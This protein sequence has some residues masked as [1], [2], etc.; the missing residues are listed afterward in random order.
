MAVL[1]TPPYLQFFDDDGLPLSGG[2]VYTY[3]ATGTFSVGKATYTTVAGDVEHPNPV[4]LD[5]SGRP[6]TGNGSIWLSGTYDFKVTDSLDNT[7]ETTLGVTAFTTLPPESDAYF[8]TFSG[9]G[10]QTAFTCSE[11]LGTDEKAI[12]VWV[13]AGAG[14]GYEIQNPSAYTINAT[15]LTFNVAPASGTNNIY[16]SAPSL[17]VGAASSSAADA[18][19]SAADAAAS[20]AA[21]LASETAAANYATKLSGTS[22]TSVAIATG[23]KAFTTQASKF[24]TVGNFLLIASDADEANYMHGQVT[25]YSGTSLTV[26]VIDTGGSGTFTDWV[27]TLSGT[28]GAVGATGSINDLSGVPSGTVTTAD[29]LV[30]DDVSDAHITRSCT[31]ADVILLAQMAN[32][33]V[34]SIYQNKTSSTN[35]ATLLGFG[36]WVQLTDVFLVARGGTYTSTGGAATDS[37]TISE[38]N[39][40]SSV[41]IDQASIGDVNNATTG[42]AKIAVSQNGARSC[43]FDISLGAGTAIT[44]DTIPPYQAIYTWE[45]TA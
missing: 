15:A 2:K 8:Q 23:S 14:K 17:L 13:D 37:I 3:T 32:L 11:D 19:S 6:T 12:Y 10:A 26:N 31:V 28:R 1:L 39:L 43:S 35:P 22:S 38:A 34:G 44:V 29:K 36:T 5:A 45:R 16:V 40:P 21:A 33:P 7:I 30:F 18:A 4:I 25:A 24:F 42:N 9:T 41:T 20:A 27:I